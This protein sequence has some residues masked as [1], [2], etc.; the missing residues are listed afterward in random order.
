MGSACWKLCYLKHGIQPDG[1]RP[2]DKTRPV[3]KERIPSMPPSE[4]GTGKPV[5]WAVLVDLEVIVV[6][7]VHTG[8]YY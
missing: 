1:Q 6:D 5:P 7:E 4:R 8:T 2:S 3:G